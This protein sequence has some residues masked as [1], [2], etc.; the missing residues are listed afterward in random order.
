ARADLEHASGLTGSA[1]SCGEQR[2]LLAP[3]REGRARYELHLALARGLE[4]DE[5]AG[6]V[7]GQTCELERGDGGVALR[8]HAQRDALRRDLLDGDEAVAHEIEPERALTTRDHPVRAGAHGLV[9]KRDRGDRDRVGERAQ[10]IA[11]ARVPSP[12]ELGLVA[13]PGAVRRDLI[14]DPRARE[15]RD[16]ALELRRS[17]WY[18][19]LRA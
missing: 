12:A 6:R 4:L 5:R 17:A 18:C 14:R 8:V 7:G 15:R 3:L 16:L 1:E 10:Q 2:A 19:D 13:R 9:R 11:E